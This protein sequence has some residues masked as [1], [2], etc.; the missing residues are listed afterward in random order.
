MD[1]SCFLPQEAQV[2]AAK[3]YQYCNQNEHDDTY[4]MPHVA[5]IMPHAAAI[6]PNAHMYRSAIAQSS[7]LSMYPSLNVCQSGLE[8]TTHLTTWPIVVSPASSLPTTK[9]LD[10]T[11]LAQFRILS[12]DAI[13]T[14]LGNL[15][16]FSCP[17]T[18]PHLHAVLRDL[19][20]LN[21]H[22]PLDGAQQHNLGV[23]LR[24][25]NILALPR[26][27]R[28]SKAFKV[29]LEKFELF[30][31]KPGHELLRRA[32]NALHFME[33]E[34]KDKARQRYGI[35]LEE[36][37]ALLRRK[38]PIRTTHDQ[39]MRVTSLTAGHASEK[40]MFLFRNT[41]GGQQ[42]EQRLWVET[43][44]AKH[45][46][47]ST[48]SQLKSEIEK[49]LIV[50]KSNA[51]QGS[52]L[53]LGRGAAGSSAAS[54][55]E[56]SD[57]ACIVLN[58]Q[59]EKCS[60]DDTPSLLP[61][62]IVEPIADIVQDNEG[63][64]SVAGEDDDTAV[65]AGATTTSS[66]N[67]ADQR[68]VVPQSTNDDRKRKRQHE[69]NA[70]ARLV[71]AETRRMSQGRVPKPA[72]VSAACNT[73]TRACGGLTGEFRQWSKDNEGTNSGESTTGSFSLILKHMKR[74][75]AFSSTSKFLDGGSGRGMPV[76]HVQQ[77]TAADSIGV[78]IEDLTFHL[79]IM[80]YMKVVAE[81][82]KRRQHG[83]KDVF[84]SRMCFIKQNLKEI[85]SFDLITHVYMF[86][87]G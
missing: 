16:Y 66:I 52:A 10:V 37:L 27:Y 83:S 4:I 12:I 7:Y 71:S 50:I 70:S 3:H 48:Y 63:I 25:I 81:N 51:A 5:A 61:E 24:K 58:P 75:C 23:L 33:R 40:M 84:N 6:I 42:R 60:D 87:V 82:E 53:A 79:S 49:R 57:T 46:N 38:S 8:Q 39:P 34:G 35:Y 21:V 69:S 67:D 31:S 68:Q 77:A 26:K 36:A 74:I 78:E 62:D 20:E 22:E 47:V 1:F 14:I 56:S 11:K 65:H 17:A 29:V 13:E 86:S 55:Q 59:D 44:T 73:F 2:P 80:G 9:S 54:N 45:S 19:C 41:H 32:I 76:T 30:A 18:H 28:N 85:A 64:M 15:Q 43:F 72:L